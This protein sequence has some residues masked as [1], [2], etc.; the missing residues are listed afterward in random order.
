MLQ[1]MLA[2]MRFIKK[3]AVRLTPFGE[4]YNP[5]KIDFFPHVVRF[6]EPNS[7]VLV[8]LVVGF[9]IIWLTNAKIHRC[10]RKMW[11]MKIFVLHQQ[12]FRFVVVKK[13]QKIL[14]QKT[15]PQSMFYLFFRIILTICWGRIDAIIAE[16][17][18]QGWQPI[19]SAA[20]T[21]IVNPQDPSISQTIHQAQTTPLS[22]LLQMLTDA[23]LT[24]Y[25]LAPLNVILANARQNHDIAALK[26]LNGLDIRRWWCFVARWFLN[27][28][29]I[30]GSTE[31][32]HN[33]LRERASRAFGT[34]RFSSVHARLTFST[35]QFLALVGGVR[36]SLTTLVNP[37][38]VVA[39]DDQ[40]ISYFG[41]DMRNESLAVQIPDKPH[42]YGL[43]SV[44]AAVKLP[45]S[46]LR[47]L[48]DMMPR[49][50]T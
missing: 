43:F 30:T 49:G 42:G 1:V 25:L 7:F 2:K 12:K 5:N 19:P 17:D 27:N 38:S 8:P 13:L 15:K 40:L 32:R 39:I 50:S 41:Q 3:T 24:R 9:F 44:G 46:G 10:M 26:R 22:I 28:V 48:I 11:K 37:G 6:N 20:L 23:T 35:T 16:A 14:P 36:H 18:A 34:E 29:N 33:E 31:K 4:N 47:L 45:K 21:L